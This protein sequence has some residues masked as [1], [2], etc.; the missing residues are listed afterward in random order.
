MC[1]SETIQTLGW[2]LLMKQLDFGIRLGDETG[3][4]K[5]CML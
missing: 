4:V 2:V 5:T 1:D 3:I